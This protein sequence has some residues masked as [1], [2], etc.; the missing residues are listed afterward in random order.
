MRRFY[1]CL[2]RLAFAPEEF[3]TSVMRLQE[4]TRAATV[5]RLCFQAAG[6]GYGH[7]TFGPRAVVVL[8]VKSV[9]SLG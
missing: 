4:K 1:H 3:A 8:T 2:R 5:A 9:A 7:L 6:N